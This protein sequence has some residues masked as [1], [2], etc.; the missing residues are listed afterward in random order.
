MMEREVFSK[1]LFLT[2]CAWISGTSLMV[3]VHSEWRENEHATDAWTSS[4]D[5][6]AEGLE[7][8]LCRPRSTGLTLKI[9]DFPNQD[10]LET[11][12]VEQVGERLRRTSGCLGDPDRLL[13]VCGFSTLR[14]RLGSRRE[15]DDRKNKCT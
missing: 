10:L 3:R 11:G 14:N 1:L 7:Q 9:G 4:P 6:R 12:Y 13:P 15:T 2:T 8:G 5:Q